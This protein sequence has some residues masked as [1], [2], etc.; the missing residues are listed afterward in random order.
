[1]ALR[2]S[3]P[4]CNH[5]LPVAEQYVARDGSGSVRLYPAVYQDYCVMPAIQPHK[6]A[7][8]AVFAYPDRLLLHMGWEPPSR[9]IADREHTQTPLT[10][11]QEFAVA[12]WVH[13][14]S[15]IR[16]AWLVLL[17]N[18]MRLHRQACLSL[19]VIRCI[20]RRWVPCPFPSFGKGRRRRV[21]P[22]NP[23]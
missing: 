1:M 19:P 16:N 12:V 17:P 10:Q 23:R 18:F 7:A 22:R 8:R 11:S 15:D 6:V 13:A 4:Y 21:L 14:G 2:R 9:R 5:K 20:Y 3:N